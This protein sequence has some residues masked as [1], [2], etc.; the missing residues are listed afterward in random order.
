MKKSVLLCSLLAMFAV[1]TMADAA[2]KAKK[3]RTP[4]IKNVQIPAAAGSGPFYWEENGVTQYS[5]TPRGHQTVGVGLVNVRTHAV[6]PLK[7]QNAAGEVMSDEDRALSLAQRQAKLNEE[8]AAENKR[9][10]EEN[11][12][13][14]EERKKNNCNTA[15]MNLQNVQAA[16]RIDNREAAIARYQ[17]DVNKYCD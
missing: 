2:P 16:N 15:R 13:R 5:D 1:V 9:R 11:A 12:R 10:E 7:V 14:E 8:I 3:M 17:A 4:S 6:E